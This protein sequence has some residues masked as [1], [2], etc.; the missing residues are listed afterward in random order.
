MSIRS[1]LEQVGAV[2][3]NTIAVTFIGDALETMTPWLITMIAV[4]LCD[5][6][7]GLRKSMKLNVHISPS[8]AAR[9]TMSKIVT[10]VAWVLAVSMIECAVGHSLAVAKW[11]CLLVC[12]IEGM[13]VVG[14]M[15]KP[16]GYDLSL[17]SG[18]LLLL[19]YAFSRS[20]EELAEL[21]EEEHTDT[22]RER[23][24]RKWEDN[25]ES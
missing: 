22:I 14:N 5:L 17:K 12:T 16:M 25:K 10:Y 3:M 1:I 24:R 18:I 4:V 2:V 21:V 20:K 19:S 6:A 8:R 11:A 15:L 13:S 7:A 23:E 9:A